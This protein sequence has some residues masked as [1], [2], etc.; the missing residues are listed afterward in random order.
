MPEDE[1]V[2][3]LARPVE[4]APDHAP[5]ELSCS[6]E[7]RDGQV[8]G[9][10]PIRADDGERLAAFHEH[11]SAR[12]V[13]R[14]FFF[15]HPKL[16]PAEI[17]RF[18]HVDYVDRL[19]LVAVDGDRLIAVGRYERVPGTADAEVAFVVADECQ[20]HGMATLLLEHLAAAAFRRGITTF[21]AETLSENRDMIGIFMKSGF[22]MTTSTDGGTVSVRFPIA[23]E[24]ATARRDA[25]ATT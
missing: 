16:S 13:Y 24:S 6:V 14:R 11:L 25:A 19:A 2:D 1:P 5:V 21:V 20:H 18:T 4:P 22:P 9:L 12:S 23:P 10:R 17:E 8:I 7:T 15:V 3:S